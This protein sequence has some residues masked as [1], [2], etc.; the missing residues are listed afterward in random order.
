MDASAQKRTFACDVVQQLRTAGY[1]ALWAGGC[2]RDALLGLEPKDYDIATS[3]TPEEVRKVFGRRRTIPV[4]VSFGVITVLGP[5]Q[6]GQIEVATFRTDGN[7]TDGRRPDSVEFATPELDASRRDFTINGLFF[8]PTTDEVL[9]YVGGQADIKAGLV[10]AIGDPVA[11]ITED[12]LRMLRAIRFAARFAFAI[13]PATQAAITRL[14]DDITQVS[15]ERIGAEMQA[16]LV[17]PSRGQALELLRELQLEQLVLPELAINTDQTRSESLAAASRLQ[18][19]SFSLALAAVLHN[20][21]HEE[22]PNSTVAKIAKRWKLSN[23]DSER[24]KWLLENLPTAS[25]ALQ[26]GWPQLQRLLVHEG[27]QELVD[28]VEAVAGSTAPA[29]KHLRAKQSLPAH[30]LNPPPLVTGAEL[31]AAGLTP[32]P[33]FRAWLETI[34]D[35]QLEGQIATRDQALALALELSRG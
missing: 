33:G 18:Q 4:G 30:Q 32:G 24:V 3:A 25:A 21:I 14:A 31:I 19:P 5:K 22:N 8:D 27:G 6:S 23:R 20:C 35:A 1:Q 26:T 9:D 2:V 34:R 11:R 28:L 17:H 10:R 13:E 12:K 15:G 16:M 29:T 7:Y